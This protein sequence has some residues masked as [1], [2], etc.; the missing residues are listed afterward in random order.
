M[1]DVQA[2]AGTLA[3]ERQALAA[4]DA[5]ALLRAL[6]GQLAEGG[7]TDRHGHSVQH[8][9]VFVIARDALSRRS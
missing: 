4:A 2:L 3:A 5:E 9:D 1:I 7:W 6:V 8:L